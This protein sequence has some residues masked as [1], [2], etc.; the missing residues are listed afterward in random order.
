M[1]VTTA[2]PFNPCANV[3]SVMASATRSQFT[4]QIQK[5]LSAG[6]KCA[7]NKNSLN[8]NKIIHIVTYKTAQNSF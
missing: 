7:K 5:K 1:F 6:R 8:N 2:A 4:N 3:R